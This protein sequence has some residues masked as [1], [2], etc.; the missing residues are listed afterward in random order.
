[1]KRIRIFFMTVA[2]MLATTVAV[3]QNGFNY[4]AVIR[5][6]GQVISDKNVTLRFSIM[7]GN[8]VCYQETQS[9]KTNAYGNIAV[10]V[11]EGTVLMGAFSAIPWETMQLAMKVEVDA[12][13]SGKYVDMGLVQIQPVPFAQYAKKIGELDSAGKLQIKAEAGTN[14]DAALFSVKDEE[15]NEVFAVYKNGVRV[16]VDENDADSKAAKSGF[17]VSGRSAK[18][19]AESQYFVV[20]ANGTQVYVDE[21]D[22]SK[23][24]KS[25]FAVAGRSGKSGENANLF[26]IDENGTQVFVDE[27]DS[28]A[29]KSKFAVAGRSGKGNDDYLIV[30]KAGTQ[31]FVDDD[32][33]DKAAKSKFAVAGRSG[34]SETNLFAVDSKGTNGDNTAAF[35]Q[36]AEA[37]GEASTAM[38][39]GAIAKGD[40]S[41]AFGYNSFAS[42]N[43]AF[44]AGSFCQ[45]D[46][47]GS[48]ALGQMS[49]AANKAAL[50][51]G[52]EAKAYGHGSCAIGIL[53]E[54]K[55][56]ASFAIGE[57]CLADS[58][59]SVAMG[60]DCKAAGN[61]ALSFGN[62]S[63][64]LDHGAV[65]IGKS[66]IAEGSCSF[67]TGEGSYAKG[68]ASVAFGFCTKSLGSYSVAIGPECVSS[69]Q[70]SI[71]LGKWLY[72][73][74]TGETVVGSAND[75]ANYGVDGPIWAWEDRLFTIGNGNGVYSRSNAMVVLKNGNIGI[76]TSTPNYL[77]EVNGTIKA[78]NVSE[79]SDVRLKNNITT[80]NNSLQKVLQ[81]RGV[82]YYWK[83]EAEIKTLLGTHESMHYPET[84]QIGVVAQE[85]EEIF[86]ELVQTDTKGFKSVDYTKLT[87]VLIEAIKE[88]QK[89]IDEL[90]AANNKLQ[91]Q[92][93]EILKKIN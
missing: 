92:I 64:A 68:G 73:K 57:N 90:K 43:G 52:E 21:D 17:A 20:N 72:A 3:A 31:V 16:Y 62:C 65:A 8:N 39:F 25:K 79:T 47:A 9:V 18:D 76:G 38:G 22:D 28:K 53:A 89:E 5:D 74:S 33:T 54:A 93:E 34:K 82:S 45:A 50:A 24:A 71:T 58:V 32:D 81:L 12:D 70:E 4:Q 6:N 1:M 30:N 10:S 87:P 7:N 60:Y 19:G 84:M 59:G 67:A 44:A 37:Q 13:G 55:G 80:L 41:S 26:A 83:P 49:I 66:A 61:W 46:S 75:T 85:V 51:L 11:G 48:V 91:S 77:L 29:A 23:A 40:N 2:A 14:D 86:P 63:K 27:D 36:Q 42:G 88:Q 56:N 69:S 35:G 78:N 15:G